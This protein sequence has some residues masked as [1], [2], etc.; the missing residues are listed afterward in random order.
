M[1]PFGGGREEWPALELA[2]WLARA[3]ELPLRLVG[4]E[5]RGGD[6]S[7]TLAAASLALQRF[8]GIA[9]EPVVVELGVEGLLGAAADASAIVASLPS[10]ELDA[11]R[12][13]LQER[14]TVAVLLVYGG[15]RPGGLAPDRSLTRFTWSVSPR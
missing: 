12:R 8:A 11:T 6:A 15:L 2:G 10:A 1:V 9:A 5:A 14:S 13:E 3:H 4:V 7:R